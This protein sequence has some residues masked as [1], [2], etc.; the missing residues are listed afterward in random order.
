MPE[1]PIEIVHL[2]G[3]LRQLFTGL[4]PEPHSNDPRGENNFLTRALA[5]FAVT[6]LTGAEPALAAAAVVDGS[7]DGGIDALYHHAAS[8][9]LY[10][11]Q[12]KWIED[13]RGEPDLG[14]VSKFRDGLTW[15]LRND[16]DAFANN[17]SVTALVPS[18]RVLFGASGMRIR[19][20]LVYSGLALLQDDRRRI[21]EDVQRRFSSDDDYLDAHICN[22]TT[23][24]D[25][26]TG[27][28]KGPGL[29]TVTLTIEKPGWVKRPFET[30]YGLISLSRLAE[31]HREHGKGLIAANIRGYKGRTDVN[32]DILAT[33]RD[34]GEHFA[35]LNNGL[36][37]YCQRLE[38]ANRDRDNAERKSITARGF[39]IVNG[40]QTL[41]SVARAAGDGELEGFAFIRVISLERCE[42]ERAFADRIT[43][44]TNFQ[45]QIGARDFAALH[46]Q[47][48]VIAR[49]LVL[50]GITYHYKADDGAPPA[51]VDNFSMEE[52]TTAC[53]CLSQSEAGDFCARVLANRR[54]L[55][56]FETV[57][58]ETEVLRS[59]CERIFRPD[60]SSRTVWRA[61]QVQRIASRE[62]SV[63]AR[64]ETAVRKSFFENARWLVLNILFL[65]HHPENGNDIR[66]SA[67]EETL[68]AAKAVEYAEALFD[69]CEAQGFVSRRAPANGGGY[70]TQRGFRSVFS[71][72]SDCDR[73]RSGLLAR[74][75]AGAS[76]GRA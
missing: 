57:Y 17:P 69:V 19:A 67:D 36:T 28:D 53:A 30:V 64:N 6:K 43:R 31:L 47:Q 40:A 18:L 24:H 25:W 38:V 44:T 66:L 45:N 13:G 75:A 29:E 37:A 32:Q 41:G 72:A 58:P 61:V 46:A 52:A 70:E 55:W 7:G 48:E 4:L 68:V 49:Q 73:L 39:S 50:S 3:K 14:G 54:S 12:S 74:L 10:I 11:V 59:R 1:L 23:V 62:M 27:A 2:P 35:Y 16:F 63:Q 56:S 71:S 65:K 34:E 21:L 42:D 22:L 33:A 76:Q 9:T 26:L 20:A 15:L 5:A 8:N 60:R 51:D